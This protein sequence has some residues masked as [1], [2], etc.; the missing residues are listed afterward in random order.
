MESLAHWFSFY[1][2]L[3]AV[4]LFAVVA[5]YFH[6]KSRT[7][8]T[9]VLAIG[10]CL[11]PI[12]ALLQLFVGAARATFDDMGNMLSHS[13]P[14]AAWYIG[15]IIS[16]TGLLITVMGFALVAFTFNRRIH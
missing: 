4:P 6:I 2:A 5:I 14:P 15:S 1:S 9:L 3:I 16:S 10:L 7:T 8:P 12:G 13:G 11:V